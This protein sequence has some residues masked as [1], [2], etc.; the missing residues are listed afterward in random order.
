MIPN[1]WYAI[2]PSTKVKSGQI[3]GVRRLNLELAVFRSKTGKLGCVVDQ[4]TH[5][6]AALRLG[7]VK[8]DCIQCPFH[9]L[10][11]DPQGKCRL[12]PAN[13][14]ASR[15]DL[16]RYN[17]RHYPVRENHGIIYLWYGDP[18]QASPDLPFFDREIDESFSYSE[19]EDHWNAHY[20]RC[21]ENQLDVVHLPFVHHNTI[22]RGN[23]TLVHGPKVVWE[24]GI[25]TTSANNEADHGQLPR[26]P[27]DSVIK[28]TYLSFRFPNLWLNHI[29]DQ[30]KVM[31]YFA[32]VDDENT[33]LYIRFYCKLANARPLNSMIACLGKFGNRM[34][35][36]QDR[37]VV[38]TQK[39]KASSLKSREKL[40][41]GDGPIIKYRKIRE[42]LN[43]AGSPDQSQRTESGAAEIR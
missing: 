26:S 1:Q 8:D 6:G 18:E 21:I 42:E 27:E 35:E 30:M 12:I 39:P 9:G 2:L 20:S 41:Q 22:G 11:F 32:P 28:E 10:R 25:L 33:V 38:I 13:G 23:K 7:K 19:I 31:I 24:K 15:A 5:R 40:L 17:L 3:V 16:S 43:Q 4:C 34:V 14:K 37:R 29:S 36:R